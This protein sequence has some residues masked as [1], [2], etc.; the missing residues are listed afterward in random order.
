MSSPVILAEIQQVLA[1]LEQIS[2]VAHRDTLLAL[3]AIQPYGDETVLE[4]VLACKALF[5][6]DR[7]AGKAFIRGSEVACQAS[8]TVLPWTRQARRFLA[9]RGSWKA[10]DGF[11]GQ[12]A[13]AY[14]S[15]GVEGEVRWATLGLDWC[16]RHLDSGVAYFRCPVLE[17]EGGHGV[18]GIEELVLP[19][20]ELFSKRRLALGTYLRGAIRVRNLLGIDAVLPW[21]KRGA[22]I[23]QAGRLRG[24]AF[25]KLESEESMALLLENLPGFRTP[26]HQR[27]LQLVLYAWF[28]VSFDLLEGNWSPDQGRAF[29]E[30]DG[31]ALYLPMALPDREEAILAVLHAAGHLVLHSFERRYIEALFREVGREH[32]PLDAQQRITWRPLF[33]AYGDDMIRFQLIFDVCEDTRVDAQIGTRIPNYCQRMLNAAMAVDPVD[34]P[35][36]AYFIWARQVLQWVIAGAP[37][38]PAFEPLRPLLGADASIVDA[39]R[40]ANRLYQNTT[41]PQISLKERDFAFMPGRA[42][43]AARPVYPRRALDQAEFGTGME[44]KD[45]VVKNQEI[46][47]NP[48]QKQIP[49]HAAGEDPD[50]DIPPEE[51]A[52][53]GGRVGVGIPQPARV[54]GYAKGAEYSEKGKPYAEWDYRDNRYKRNWAWVQEKQLTELDEHEAAKIL[55]EYAPALKRLKRA[56]QTQKPTRM[57]PLRRQFDGDELDLEATIAYVVE[58][59][60]GMSPQ[61]NIYRQRVVQHRDTA[62]VLLADISTSIMQSCAESG[63]RVVDRIRAGMLLFAESMEEVGDPYSLA[64]FASKY[65]DNV[66]YYTIKGFDERLTPHTRA[67][68]GGLTGRLATRMGAAIRHAVANFDRSPSARRLLLIL[69]DGRPADYDDGGDERYLHE[70][71]RMAVKE[72]ADAGVHLFCIT[73][74][75]AGSEYLPQIFGAGHY[76]ILNHIDDLPKKLPEVYLRLRK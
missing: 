8:H 74:D 14:Q 64:G 9:W 44:D 58:K 31:D 66:S 57:A 26:E 43:N 55:T 27:L 72:A 35:A 48:E 67:V 53:S 69:S 75:A 62:V 51:T 50:F 21:A 63:G 4:W 12:L 76:L 1:D 61:A 19:S 3:S 49:K 34:G 13:E 5:E 32:P 20:L 17:L 68:L 42:P 73:L 70:D 37:A 28:G 25:F 33:A 6:H 23:L 59:R 60:A 65:R 10:V 56:I 11:M 39:F 2:F 36:A 47:P 40:I 16:G 38:D 71:T 41:L 45:D 18:E 52:G 54:L 29:V 30:T 24:E 22:D 46:K 7:D 15:L